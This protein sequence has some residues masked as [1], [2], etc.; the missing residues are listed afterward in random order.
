M[1]H[2][3]FMTAVVPAADVANARTL[4]GAFTE[5]REQR[6]FNRVQH[7]EPQ[8]LAV[9]GLP[10]AKEL[11]KERV[12]NRALWQELHQILVK[13]PSTLQVR[14]KITDE[15][16]NAQAGEAVTIAANKPRV[17][18]WTELPDPPSSRI[19]PFITQ[20]RILEI[21]DGRMEQILAE[22]RFKLK[23]ELVDESYHWWLNDVEF[24]LTRTYVLSLNPDQTPS[25]QVPNLASIQ[26]V[27]DFWILYVRTRVDSTP[28]RTQQGQMHLV[29]VREQLDELFDFKVFD[30]R[31]FDTR[32]QGPR[33]QGPA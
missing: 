17:L 31:F 7:F 23:S 28:E 1:L 32:I 30:R 11:Q 2:D 15:V 25:Q 13:Q 14:T 4:I 12:P 27:S 20:R 16:S 33:G 10:K 24:A 6:Q 19:P 26:P 29:R 9:K 18:R 5:M 22:N 3:I 8:D 21:S